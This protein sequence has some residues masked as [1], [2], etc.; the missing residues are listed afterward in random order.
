MNLI[1]QEKNF[2]KVKLAEI[3]YAL[4]GMY[5]TLSKTFILLIVA[6]LIGHL[7]DSLYFLLFYIPLR[8]VSFG[9]HANSSFECLLLS[10]VGFVLLPWLFSGI[11]ISTNMQITLYAISFICFLLFS[12]SS[13][14]KRPIKKRQRR[15]WYKVISSSLIIFYFILSF[16]V[17]SKVGNMMLLTCLFQSFMITPIMYIIFRQKY[18]YWWFK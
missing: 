10:S 14:Q 5:S 18:T 4:D 11:D 7:S 9:F 2:D 17:S 8:S 1:E 12:P 3:R 13:T 15:I 6:Y 16:F